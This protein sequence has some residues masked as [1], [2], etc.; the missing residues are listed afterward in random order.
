MEDVGGG[1]SVLLDQIIDSLSSIANPIENHGFWS[2]ETNKNSLKLGK[3][4]ES[5][6]EKG[7][8]MRKKAEVLIIG[9]SAVCQP[10][11]ELLAS[12]GSISSCH[13]FETCLGDDFQE[14]NNV[15]VIVASLYLKDAEEV[16]EGI[17]NAEAIRVDVLDHRSLCKYVSQT[18]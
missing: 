2:K 11:A 17:P 18:I 6:T 3:V 8:G 9:A 4:N 1:D 7:R 13:Q 10:A 12:F 5:G 15:Q 14:Q 16:I